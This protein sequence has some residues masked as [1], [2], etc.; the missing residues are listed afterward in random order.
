[1]A[2][3]NSSPVSTT[4][5]SEMPS[6]PRCQEIPHS[7]IHVCLETNWKPASPVSKAASIQIVSANVMAA[8]RS[9]TSLTISGRR[10]GVRMTSTA[11]I[12][13]TRTSA[14][15]IGKPGSF[16]RA[17]RRAELGAVSD[18]CWQRRRPDRPMAE[19]APRYPSQDAP[20][21]DE[22]GEEDDDADADQ[23]GVG[24]DEAAL[25]LAQLTGR[26]RARRRRC[27]RPPRRR[28]WHRTR[29]RL[30]RPRSR[31]RP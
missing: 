6:T 28:R 7:S 17:L 16:T 12:T 18:R 9:P 24:A 30:L 29:R 3:G 27:P 13:G 4:R 5:N 8:A 26:R 21:D 23:R 25:A 11:P 15:R 1:M 2:S 22:P 20:G 14:V 31:G 10:L 19:M